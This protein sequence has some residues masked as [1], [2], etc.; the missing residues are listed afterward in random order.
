VCV[1]GCS[2][3]GCVNGISLLALRFARGQSGS[4]SALPWLLAVPAIVSVQQY[5]KVR[6]CCWAGGTV[7]VCVMSDWMCECYG[8]NLSQGRVRVSG[9]VT[10]VWTRIDWTRATHSAYCLTFLY[11]G[12]PLGTGRCGWLCPIE[13]CRNGTL[14]IWCFCVSLGECHR[15]I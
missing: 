12:K 5:L 13:P 6:T 15:G 14:P 2:A 7:C 3:R 8:V 10:S 1:C 11:S 4:F 9:G